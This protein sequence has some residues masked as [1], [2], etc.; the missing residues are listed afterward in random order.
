MDILE[1][2]QTMD[3]FMNKIY[4]F[5]FKLIT[6]QILQN[7]KRCLDKPFNYSKQFHLTFLL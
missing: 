6:E 1:Y 4:L 5:C 2:L 7:V 3:A